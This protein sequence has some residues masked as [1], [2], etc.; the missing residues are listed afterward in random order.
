MIKKLFLVVLA[1]SFCM[2]SDFTKT[3]KELM[4][5]NDEAKIS[6]Q[7]IDKLDSKTK[8]YLNQYRNLSSE[9]ESL[10]NY[11]KQLEAKT[12]SLQKQIDTTNEQIASIKETKEAIVPLIAR[13]I[14]AYD[15]LINADLPF[16]KQKRLSRAKELNASN[17]QTLSKVYTDVM[18]AY[19]DEYFLSNNIE[20]YQGDLKD[21]KVDFLRVGRV[22]LYYL[23]LDGLKAGYFDKK[24]QKFLPLDERYVLDIKNAIKIAKKQ[25]A[26]NVLI[27][28]INTTELDKK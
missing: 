4:Q 7:K 15:E 24:E 25:T 18:N 27:L 23:S 6:Q 1:V 21:K 10:K 13:M 12:T 22:G 5:L 26:P 16:L 3:K 20:S 9:F 11:N 17:D 8:E 2:G 19:K 28:P 14:K